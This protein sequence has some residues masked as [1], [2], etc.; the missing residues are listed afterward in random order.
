MT[1]T[2]NDC[3]DQA[4]C[5]TKYCTRCVLG[6]DPKARPIYPLL[7]KRGRFYECPVC[8]ASYGEHPHP[9]LK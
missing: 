3:E 1:I 2:D 8:D 6:F 5:E 7:V 4:L 9:D